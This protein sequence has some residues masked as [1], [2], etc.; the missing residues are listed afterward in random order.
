MDE[1]TGRI[2]EEVSLSKADRYASEAAVMMLHRKE[3]YN[4][5][6]QVI[7]FLLGI[8]INVLSVLKSW[9]FC[10]GFF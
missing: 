9:G 4:T 10:V 8:I 5:D 7:T 3:K 2:R 1:T 6:G